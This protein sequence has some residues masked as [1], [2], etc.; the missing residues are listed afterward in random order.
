MANQGNKTL[1]IFD[2]DE[3]LVHATKTKFEYEPDF[4]VLP[5]FVYLRPEVETL[6]DYCSANFDL[7][8]WSSSSEAYVKAVTDYIFG[9]RYSIKFAWSEKRCVQKIDLISGG[10]VYIKDL[11]KV[12]S[13]GYDLESIIMIDDSPEKIIRQP[14]NLLQISAFEGDQSDSELLTLIDRLKAKV[15]S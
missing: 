6:L 1:I 2:L 4:S 13:Q 14:K 3:T 11:R 5:Y 10:Y 12:R 7:A 15:I 9:D 8:V